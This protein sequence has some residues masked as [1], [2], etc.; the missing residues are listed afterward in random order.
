MT[1]RAAAMAA[2]LLTAAT[3]AAGERKVDVGG[4][5]L[6]LRCA[7]EGAP[8]V[9]LDAGAGER[10]QTWDWVFPEI[11]E[12]TRVCAYDRA[13]LGKSEAGPS[14]R[15]SERIVRELDE[16]LRRAKVP[17]PYVLVGHSFG[18]LNVR[19]FASTHP[20]AT[21]G[22]VLVD[23][24]P[25]DFPAREAEMRTAGEREKART[26]R[27]LAPAAYGEEI[28]A[29]PASAV[30]VRQAPPPPPVPVR[31]LTAGHPGDSPAFRGTWLE[32][33]SRL[34]EE[35]PR[36][37]QVMAPDSGHYIQFDAPEV[38]VSAIRDVV[39]EVRA[40]RKSGS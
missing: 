34:A 39:G 10:L 23:A 30:S 15:T 31:V 16:L 27:A 20:E 17:G 24:T 8:T 4:F 26:F 5:K 21:A 29:M 22:L 28:D 14:P 38:V 33:Q 9:V 18:G 7:G 13:G 35:F 37:R 11:R 2:A 12:F 32:L 40:S 19:L 6:N 25:V 36:A 3:A 1:R